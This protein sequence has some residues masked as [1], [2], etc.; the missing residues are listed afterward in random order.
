MRFW[1]WRK[2]IPFGLFFQ[3]QTTTFFLYIYWLYENKFKFIINWTDDNNKIRPIIL[4]KKK[5]Y[6]SW[7]IEI[8]FTQNETKT[9]RR[10]VSKKKFFF[11]KNRRNTHTQLHFWHMRYLTF[12]IIISNETKKKVFSDN[13]DNDKL[14]N[15]TNDWISYSVPF[16]C[17]IKN[18]KKKIDRFVSV[19]LS[20][21]F[22]HF[23]SIYCRCVGVVSCTWS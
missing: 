15:K 12:T 17:V 16:V 13:S 2:N 21:E 4:S 1:D 11:F 18:D 5:K 3:W 23:F 10:S 22:I 6:R 14:K 7:N 8:L 9:T 19:T 20:L